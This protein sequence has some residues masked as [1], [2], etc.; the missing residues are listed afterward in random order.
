MSALEKLAQAV[1]DGRVRQDAP[2]GRI[3]VKSA[4]PVQREDL[5]LSTARNLSPRRKLEILVAMGFVRQGDNHQSD[6]PYVLDSGYLCKC[7]PPPSWWHAPTDVQ[8]FMRETWEDRLEAAKKPRP[9]YE[10][11]R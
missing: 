7:V 10:V 4:E 9:I 3:I 6:C 11:E 5:L 1:L 2:T 8:V